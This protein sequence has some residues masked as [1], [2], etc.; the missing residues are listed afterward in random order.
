MS[1]EGYY[2]LGPDVMEPGDVV[3]VLYGGKVPFVLRPE[4]NWWKLLGECYIHGVMA[5][6][7]LGMGAEEEIFTIC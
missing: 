5:G 2:I 7:A 4:G 1:D 6:E 3:V